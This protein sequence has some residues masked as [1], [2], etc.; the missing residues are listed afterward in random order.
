[1]GV[2]QDFPNSTISY[3]FYRRGPSAPS[4]PVPKENLVSNRQRST[5]ETVTGPDP[6]EDVSENKLN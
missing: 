3:P 4:E 6:C 1:M 2:E 5:T